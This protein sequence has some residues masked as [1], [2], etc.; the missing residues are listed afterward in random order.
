[1]K[2][3][4]GE[5][6][7]WRKI[8]KRFFQGLGVCLMLAAG[9]RLA[10]HAPLKDS[11]VY[12]RIVEDGNGELLRM[13]LADDDHYRLWLPLEQISPSMID[14][15][16]LKED[17][18]FHFHPGFNPVSILRAAAATWLGGDRQGAST[19]SMQLA[20]R[21]YGVNSRT[22]MGKLTQIALALWLE[23]RYSKKDILEAYLNLA[24]MGGNLEGVE[25]AS[26][27]YFHKPASALSLNEAL[28]LA[29]I[30][31]SPTKR[32]RF[33]DNLQNARSLLVEEWRRTYP[34]DVRTSSLLDLPATG[35]QRNDLPFLAPHYVDLLLARHPDPYVQG[36]LDIHLQQALEKIVSNYV[37]EREGQGV[38]NATVLLIDTRDLGV[39][40]MVG[41][42]D[43]LS[44]AI[45]G[46]VNGTTSR[47]SPGSTVKPFLYALAIDQGI[48][49]PMT[50]L[51]DAPSMFGSFQPENFDGR[52]AGPLSAQDALVRSRNVPAVWLASQTRNPTLYQFLQRGGVTGLRPEETYGLAI[53][54]GGGEL[55][56]TELAQL[57]ALLAKDGRFRSLRY[58]KQ[59]VI[60]NGPQL[61]SPEAAFITRDMLRHNP[62]P[63]G[64]PADRRGGAWKVA[65]KTGTSWGYHDA[66]TAGIVGPYALVVWVGNFDN[67]NNVGFIGL[68]SA[69][70]LFFRIADALP[71]IRPMDADKEDK[72]P[73]GVARVDIC[74]A[75]GDLPNQWCP[76]TRKTWFIP[77][78]SPIKLSTL[79]QPVMIDTRTGKAAC[80]PWDPKFTRQEVFEFWPSDLQQLFKA[81]GLPR[82]SPPASEKD[83]QTFA[84]QGEAPRIKHPVSQVAYTLKLSNPEDR[85]PLQASAGADA[86]R[87]Y[88]FH[89]Q[90][91]L[92]QTRPGETL[93]WRPLRSGAIRLYVSDDHGRSASRTV[94]VDF[95]P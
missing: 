81:A 18:Y 84:D 40:A 48:I 51:K 6:C 12:S 92:G 19:L 64:L 28:T 24:P 30:P 77:G 45:Q 95:I 7:R 8:L 87:L 60:E 72:P 63:D 4:G 42:A 86:V 20:R 37:R 5:G 80:P 76:Q 56:M 35:F 38:K 47:R 34:D 69:A 31:Q 21:I 23:A 27:I 89:E 79:H 39:R 82:K 3:E 25:A 78:V 67:K 33:G 46:Q 62:R 49:H 93:E 17:R 85:I 59:D 55:K 52:F 36:T 57:Y 16:M 65:W 14:A 9:L 10:P 53:A 90:R 91:L 88:W 74:A 70:P 58:R 68:K 32:A 2:D 83:C 75:S 26:R 22:A 94:N 41:S 71:L 73:S 43:Y 50:M 44:V 15:L 11:A 61:I 1:M 66:W 54:L 29:V 13:T